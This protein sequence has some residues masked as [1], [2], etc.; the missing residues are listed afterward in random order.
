MHFILK[1]KRKFD[2]H[3]GLCGYGETLNFV[4]DGIKVMENFCKKFKMLGIE[5]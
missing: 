5:N 3:D 1:I 4:I 2:M